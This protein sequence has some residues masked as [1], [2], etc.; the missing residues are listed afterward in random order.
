MI[1]SFPLINGYTVSSMLTCL[2]RIMFF[3]LMVVRGKAKVTFRPLSHMAVRLVDQSLMALAPIYRHPLGHHASFPAK[4]FATS[5]HHCWQ[6][7]SDSC[8]E[9]QESW[10]DFCQPCVM[11]SLL[12]CHNPADLCSATCDEWDSL[13]GS[14][15]PLWKY[16]H[17]SI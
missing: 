1:R 7:H 11:W 8:L 10:C 6:D 15:Y 13:Y 5:L 3:K 9:H 16:F 4:S 12:C 14:S 2:S 17:Y